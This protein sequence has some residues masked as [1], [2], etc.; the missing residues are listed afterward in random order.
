MGITVRRVR[1]VY[2]PGTG[3]VCVRVSARRPDAERDP[4]GQ[5]T[6]PIREQWL[7]WEKLAW[8]RLDAQERPWKR[9]PHGRAGTPPGTAT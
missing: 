5:V 7:T 8:A 4:Q 2:W 9:N 3:T 6:A 1:L